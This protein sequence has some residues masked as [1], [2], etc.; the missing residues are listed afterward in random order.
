MELDEDAL[1]QADISSLKTCHFAVIDDDIVA[2][3]AAGP[4]GH[5]H[6]AAGGCVDGRACGGCINLSGTAG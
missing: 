4:A 2:V 5:L 3:A 6:I 1:K